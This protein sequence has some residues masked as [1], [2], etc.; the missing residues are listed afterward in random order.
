MQVHIEE[1]YEDVTIDCWPL[2]IIIKQVCLMPNLNILSVDA[3]YSEMAKWSILCSMK[4]IC[5]C[6]GGTKANHLGD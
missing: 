4:W 2:T 6:G 1:L 3:F 5:D